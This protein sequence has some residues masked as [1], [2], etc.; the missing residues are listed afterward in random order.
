MENASK[1]LIIAGA[2]LISILIIAL[3]VFI[4]QRAAGS[5]Q[6]VGGLD[7]TQVQ[8]VNQKFE[9]Y[10]G[11][12][13]SGSDVRALIDLVRTNN[14]TYPSTG[15]DNRSIEIKSTAT[16][17]TPASAES[18]A[19]LGT[20]KNNVKTGSSYKVTISGYDGGPDGGYVSEITI[21]NP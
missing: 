20:L 16:G 4:Y 7:E 1:A 15:G 17:L 21:A 2:I 18:A 8:S 11:N 6:D 13:V 14:N 3:G 5:A 19:N 10:E 9:N 12:S